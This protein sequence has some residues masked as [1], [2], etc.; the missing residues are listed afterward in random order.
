MDRRD[1][2]QSPLACSHGSLVVASDG[3]VGEV[4]TPFF[5]PDA[6]EPDFLLVHRRRRLRSRRPVV[7]VSLVRHVEPSVVFLCATSDDVDRLP[8]HLPLA[9]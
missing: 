9:L 4:E 2:K 1:R 8:E 3:L 6:D 5:P 7:H